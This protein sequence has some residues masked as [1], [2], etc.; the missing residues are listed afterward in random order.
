MTV[1]PCVDGT[2]L[3]DHPAALIK[4]GQ[5]SKVDMMIGTANDEGNLISA[6][7]NFFTTKYVSVS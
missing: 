3:P 5:Y 6:G 7:M 1:G 4:S 2:F